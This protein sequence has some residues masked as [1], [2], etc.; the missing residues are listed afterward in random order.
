MGGLGI[1]K[2]KHINKVHLL[3][4]IWRFF[5][6]PDKEWTKILTNKY[7]NAWGSKRANKYHTFKI[8]KQTL[9]LYQLCTKSV[10]GDGVTTNLWFDTWLSKP[11]RQ[12]IL[13]PIPCNEDTWTVSSIYN[14]K[15]KEKGT[16]WK[17]HNI[18][19]ILPRQILLEISSLPNLPTT[20]Y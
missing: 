3:S 16:C 17:L 15:K 10:I 18:S 14:R 19:F 11:I 12:S 9:P 13:G 5:K 7:G 6:F 1:R 4:L 20:L 2:A 8:F